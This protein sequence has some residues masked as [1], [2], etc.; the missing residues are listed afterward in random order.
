MFPLE[1]LRHR[2]GLPRD[3]VGAQPLEVFKAR[4]DVPRAARA[5]GGEPYGTGQIL[6]CFST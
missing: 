5:A 3:A 6:S 4:L 1:V 2:L